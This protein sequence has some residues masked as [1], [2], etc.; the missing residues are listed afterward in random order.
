[1]LPRVCFW[2]LRFSLSFGAFCFSL[3]P[4]CV[5]HWGFIEST[6]MLL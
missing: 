2:L 5:E 4:L 6:Y 3:Y 1:M